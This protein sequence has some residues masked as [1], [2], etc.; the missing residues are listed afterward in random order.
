MSVYTGGFF[1]LLNVPK[2]N[3]IVSFFMNFITLQ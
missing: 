2:T 3:V 1:F